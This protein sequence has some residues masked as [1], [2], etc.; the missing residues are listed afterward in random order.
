MGHCGHLR[1]GRSRRPVM[2]GRTADDR[3]VQQL[4]ARLVETSLVK[5]FRIGWHAGAL[6]F[7]EA[8][9]SNAAAIVARRAS[10]AASRL[11]R[12]S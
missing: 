10:A 5:P 4:A 2:G 6:A 1:A 12:S 3:T 11:P 7:A 9:F 8:S